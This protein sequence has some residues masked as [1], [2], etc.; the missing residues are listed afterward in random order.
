MCC[1]RSQRHVI[2]S[3]SVTQTAMTKKLSWPQLPGLQRKS[4]QIWHWS[5]CHWSQCQIWYERSLTR[6]MHFFFCVNNSQDL[7]GKSII[8]QH[9]NITV[10][11][12]DSFILR[13]DINLSLLLH[14]KQKHQPAMIV[15][16]S[17]RHTRLPQQQQ[18]AYP[19]FAGRHCSGLPAFQ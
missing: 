15:V 16:R 3:C 5:Q 1:V 14:C 6:R 10:Q 18:F 11:K 4:H 13:M 12:S 9:A 19:R 7:L 8:T 17:R 2:G